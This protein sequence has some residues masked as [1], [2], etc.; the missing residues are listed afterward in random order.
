MA[1]WSDL[2]LDHALQLV[3]RRQETV[4][5]YGEA[6]AL[7]GTVLN[8]VGLIQHQDLAREVDIHLGGKC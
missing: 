8:V 7:S 3:P 2:V 4:V 5:V 6:G 1:G